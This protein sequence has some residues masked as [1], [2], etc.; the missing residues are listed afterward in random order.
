MTLKADRETYDKGQRPKFRVR[1]TSGRKCTV[2]L[3]P[4][5]LALTVTS[6]SDRIWSSADCARADGDTTRKISP[7]A[8][9]ETEVTW[10][11]I[12]SH[13]DDCG[14]GERQSARPG[15]YVVVAELGDSASKRDVFQIVGA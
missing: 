6:G 3:G 13:P 1:I 10:R 11:R 8:P 4:K 15:W 2:D 7:H 9:Y 14:G 12:R 5:N